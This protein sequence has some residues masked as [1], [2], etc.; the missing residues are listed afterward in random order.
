MKRV[1]IS[2]LGLLLAACFGL[3]A[4]AV[5][6]QID[7]GAITPATQVDFQ[8]E[9]VGPLSLPAFFDGFVF[10]ESGS[11]QIATADA[12]GGSNDD[13]CL[14]SSSAIGSL[15]FDA[16]DR[17][18]FGFDLFSTPSTIS[19]TVTGNSGSVEFDLSGGGQFGFFD[20]QGLTSISLTNLS[21]SIA[22]P[23]T[24]RVPFS[25]KPSPGLVLAFPSPLA[26]DDVVTGSAVSQVP[27]PASSPLILAGL[28]I[29]VAMRRRRDRRNVGDKVAQSHLLSPNC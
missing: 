20:P 11:P 10:T 18:A 12:C 5:P 6:V 26:I 13:R 3:S 19:A 24:D 9:N 22:T 8:S 15:I 7:Y 4:Q 25:R 1:Q 14:L 28:G 16:L 17:T 29:I 21:S 23:P 2:G 27:L